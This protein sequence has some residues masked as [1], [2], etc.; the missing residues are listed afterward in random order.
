MKLNMIDR[1]THTNVREFY[2]I[3]FFFAVRRECMAG[4]IIIFENIGHDLKNAFFSCDACGDDE[5]GP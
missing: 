5:I 4:E 2:N 3:F 1:E